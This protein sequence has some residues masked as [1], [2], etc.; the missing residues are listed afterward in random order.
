MVPQFLFTIV[1]YMKFWS[2]WHICMN[3]YVLKWVP[4]IAIKNC[5]KIP[6]VYDNMF[7]FNYFLFVAR[8]EIMQSG[9]DQLSPMDQTKLVN[10][11][12]SPHE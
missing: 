11:S 3:S 12:Q 6:V 7:Y 2:K 10:L 9:P 4:C 5:I 8:N 1:F